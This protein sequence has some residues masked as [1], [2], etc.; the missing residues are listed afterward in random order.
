[1]A[2][3]G[4]V[5][6]CLLSIVTINLE[7]CHVEYKQQPERKALFVFGDSLFDPGNDRYVK[8]SSP[9]P[10]LYWPY[11]E[12]FFHRATGRFSD[13]R[14]PPDFIATYAG[15]PILPPYTEPTRHVFTDGANFAT[16][17]ACVLFGTTT[18]NDLPV[19]VEF[20]KQM[21]GLLKK[22]VGDAEAER[23]LTNAVYLFSIGG[24]DYLNFYADYPDA[25]EASMRAFVKL[26]IGNLYKNLQ[27]ITSLGARKIAFQN[28]GPIGCNPSNRLSDGQCNDKEN[29]M[30]REHNKALIQVMKQL[31]REVSGFKYSI[32]DFYTALDD[33]IFNPHKYGFKEGQVACCGGGSFGGQ[34][35]CGGY[36]VLPFELCSNPFEYVYFDAGHNTE[37]FNSQIA[38]LIWDGSP[39]SNITSP[40]TL[41]QLYH[42]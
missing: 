42:M 37:G 34:V 25:N 6:C 22:E 26:V 39:F 29:S 13:G 1:M 14:I 12:T 19:Q 23:V 40:Y 35:T 15:L 28:V 41:K 8:A 30:A 27:E 9:L 36:G 38:H 21:I 33:R 11:G 31:E 20:F 4:Y 32:F 16:G 2:S 24:D 10:T 3:V 7:R 5:I 17:G 18:D